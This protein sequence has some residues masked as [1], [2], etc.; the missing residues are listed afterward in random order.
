MSTPTFSVIIP[1]YDKEA[2]V[3]ATLRSALEQSLRPLEVIVVDDGSTDRS[4]EIV[5]AFRSPLVRL[6]RQPN[7]GVSAARNRAIAEARGEYVALLDAD[8]RWRPGF[9][10]EIASMIERWPDCGLYATA[11][12][13]V[14]DEGLVPGRTP[15]ERGP[16][17]DFFTRSMSCYVAI[18]S[19]S[20]IPT[21][22]SPTSAKRVRGM[23]LA[24]GMAT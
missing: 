13:I 2:E 4:A 22:K 5:A 10:A 16:V 17:D 12:D 20:F 15:R 19:P 9:L 21:G 11:F 1:L 3:A 6:I 23:T 7:A 8:D 18:P 24:E 14:S